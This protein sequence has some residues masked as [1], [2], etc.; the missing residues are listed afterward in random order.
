M[1]SIDSFTEISLAARNAGKRARFIALMTRP[2]TAILTNLDIALVSLVGGLL[3]INGRADV[4]T[5]AIFLQYTRQL[6]LPI[7]SISNSLDQAA[8][9]PIR[10]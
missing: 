1:R 10:R 4:G 7:T 3:A 8:G 5:V 9:G 2:V 6:A